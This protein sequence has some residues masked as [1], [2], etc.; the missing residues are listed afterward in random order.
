[1]LGSSECHECPNYYILTIL[2]NV[3]GALM[4]MAVLYI[5][6]VTLAVGLFNF[7]IFFAQLSHAGIEDVVSYTQMYSKNTGLVGVTKTCQVL[8]SL[9]NLM[10]DSFGIPLCFFQEY[11]SR[12]ENRAFVIVSF[13]H[14]DFC[15]V[16]VSFEQEM[17]VAINETIAVVC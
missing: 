12:M 8:I 15:A 9:M 14:V 2:L 6:R 16:A 4:A 3:L 13:F 11:D 1:M 5:G 17:G 7:V 10:F